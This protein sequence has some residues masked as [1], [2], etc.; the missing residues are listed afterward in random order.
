[1]P[2]FVGVDLGQAQDFT[3]VVIAEQQTRP[4]VSGLPHY[5][6]S[7]LDHF[8]LGTASLRLSGQCRRYWLGRPCLDRVL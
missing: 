2:Y 6:V 1:M 3:A 4:Q 7:H 5:A 8:Q